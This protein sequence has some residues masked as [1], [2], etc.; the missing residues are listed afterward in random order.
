MNWANPRCQEWS[1]Q[2]KNGSNRI[3][4]EA[5]CPVNFKIFTRIPGLQQLSLFCSS[6]DAQ[7]EATWR[8]FWRPIWYWMIWMVRCF[9]ILRLEV[10]EVDCWSI[11]LWCPECHKVSKAGK[12]NLSQLMLIV[13]LFMPF[14]SNQSPT[15]V[16][17]VGRC[18][19]PN[20][21]WYWASWLYHIH[22]TYRYCMFHMFHIKPILNLANNNHHW[23]NMNRTLTNPNL[24]LVNS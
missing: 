19:L 23:P 2:D 18:R 14:Y 24:Q 10:P 21:W 8:R 11:S 17:I 5:I 9:R 4:N 15:F 7:K 3:P 12:P 1:K 13:V 16:T 20:V 6:L 22:E